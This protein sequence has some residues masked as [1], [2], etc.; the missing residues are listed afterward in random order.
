[1]QERGGHSDNQPE[2]R[3]SCDDRDSS[4]FHDP[5]SM[6]MDEG[7]SGQRESFAD[8]APQGASSGRIHR[9]WS[10]PR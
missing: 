10:R 4:A 2:Q 8:I 7:R 9:K 3:H 6:L 5:P 1:M